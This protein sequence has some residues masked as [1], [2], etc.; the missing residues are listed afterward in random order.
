MSEPIIY[1][2]QDAVVTLT[3]NRPENLNVIAEEM[4]DALVQAC[5]KINRDQSVSCVIVTGAGK[6]F[7]S[8][9]NV[10]QMRDKAGIFSD[11]SA[12]AHRQDYLHGIQRM[13]LALY[14]LEVPSIAAVNG[15][16]VG[17]GCDLSL[18]CDIRIASEHAVFAESFLRLGL[19][20][21]DGGAWH[22]PRVIGR[23]RAYEMTFT[24]EFIDAETALRYGLVSEV[25][26]ADQLLAAAKS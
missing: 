17:A 12:P 7:S 20:S 25:V 23:A 2:Q 6:S 19:V 11:K 15:H 13:P 8:G 21:G 18:M 22:L 5:A 9:G 10:K 24:A 1:E 3:L 16:A 4:V 14:D 26:P